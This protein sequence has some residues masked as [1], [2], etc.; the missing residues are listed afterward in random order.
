MPKN[1]YK[2]LKSEVKAEGNFPP[3][4]RITF[5]EARNEAD[6]TNANDYRY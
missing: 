2:R 4:G 6:I 1:K 3:I 5:A